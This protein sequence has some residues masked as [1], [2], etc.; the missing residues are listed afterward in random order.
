MRRKMFSACS[1]SIHIS[2]NLKD[3]ISACWVCDNKS[4]RMLSMHKHFFSACSARLAN[5][6]AHT[7]HAQKHKMANI[8][9]SLQ[10]KL[11][12]PVLKSHTQIGLIN[13][14]NWSKF[15]HLGTFKKLHFFLLILLRQYWV[16]VYTYSLNFVTKSSIKDVDNMINM[17]L[18]TALV[19]VDHRCCWHSG[20]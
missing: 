16:A 8:C 9:R 6:F 12:F 10:N 20:G 15:S 5:V 18:L 3:W 19:I 2:R 1:A 13:V 11:F 7:Q 4:F 17:S 14:K